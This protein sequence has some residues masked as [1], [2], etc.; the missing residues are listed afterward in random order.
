MKRRRIIAAI[1]LLSGV[2]LFF[3]I[4]GG[5]PSSNAPLV[6]AQAGQGGSGALDY[7]VSGNGL[8]SG[9][10]SDVSAAGNSANLTDALINGYAQNILQM[11]NGLTGATPNA[12]NTVSFPSVDATNQMIAQNLGQRLAFR[13]YGTG[14]LRVTNDSSTPSQIQYFDAVNALVQK[15]LGSFHYSV[16]EMISDMLYSNNS[17]PINQYINITNQVTADLLALAVPS[18]LTNWAVSN[19]DLWSEKGAV[20]TAIA[21]WNDDPAKAIVGIGQISDL[22]SK[23]QSVDQSMRQTLARATAS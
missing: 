4:I 19:I 17:E 8:P 21:G 13:T 5:S 1:V 14:D 23:G 16:Q 11:N 12:T 10:S 18:S 6:S 22:V 15:D 7:T 2:A 9:G 3:I 20:F